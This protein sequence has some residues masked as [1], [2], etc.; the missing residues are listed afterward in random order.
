MKLSELVAYRNQLNRLH[1][2]EARTRTDLD[3]SHIKHLINQIHEIKVHHQY[4]IYH[5]SF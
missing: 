1:I 3:I 5:I 4:R 2:E